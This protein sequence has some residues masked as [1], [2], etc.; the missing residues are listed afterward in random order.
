LSPLSR[1]GSGREKGEGPGVRALFGEI[2]E[3]ESGLG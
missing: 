2:D 3:R 1:R